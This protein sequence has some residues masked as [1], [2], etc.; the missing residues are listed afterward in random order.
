MKDDT[1][2]RYWLENE[3]L[4]FTGG[5]LYVPSIKLR[6]ELLKETHDTKWTGHPGEERTLA[7]LSRSF[8]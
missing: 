5:K 8:H 7:L 6:R 3:M 2:R 4:Y 1:T